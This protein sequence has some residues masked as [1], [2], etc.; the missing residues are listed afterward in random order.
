M[1]PFYWLVLSTIIIVAVACAYYP[2]LS[3]SFVWDDHDLVEKNTQVLSGKIIGGVFGSDFWVTFDDPSRFSE[4]YRP[5]IR[6]SFAID[7]RIYGLNAAGFHATNLLLHALAALLLAVVCMQLT[8]RFSAALVSALVFSLHPV[9]VESVAWISGRTDVLCLVFALASL[10]AV[11]EGLSRKGLRSFFALA[12]SVIFYAGALLSKETAAVLPFVLLAFI[13]LRSTGGR[14]KKGMLAAGLFF[15]ELSV[16][17]AIHIK[18]TGIDLGGD[19]GSIGERFTVSLAS[20]L[21]YLKLLILP[22][23]LKAHYGVEAVEPSFDTAA[24]AVILLF[25]ICAVIKWRETFKKVPGKNISHTD[26]EPLFAFAALL[27]AG[28]LLPVVVFPPYSDPILAERFLYFPGAA[29]ALIAGGA[30]AYF[31]GRRRLRW[32][33]LVAAAM[34]AAGYAAADNVRSRDWLD[35]YTLFAETARNTESPMIHGNYANALL[36]RHQIKQAISEFE[37]I[38]AGDPYEWR[39]LLNH[40][41]ALVSLGDY[42]A[43]GTK[44]EKALKINPESINAAVQLANV[45]DIQGRR[46]DASKM[47]DRALSISGSFAPAYYNLGVFYEKSKEYGPALTQYNKAIKLDP[48]YTNAYLGAANTCYLRGGYAE[49]EKY[50]LKIIELAGPDG[51]VFYDLAC[52]YSLHG[53]LESAFGALARAFENGYSA[54]E[55]AYKDPDLE[56]LRKSGERFALLVESSRSGSK[57]R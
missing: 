51:Q 15:I 43:A 38:E 13:F 31:V 55:W 1:K 47:Y 20:L 6:S 25:A 24:G 10:A 9:H 54:F 41:R 49:A 3:G 50:F 52:T 34:I 35:D 44:F 26:F 7:H 21:Y 39:A 11:F 5:L 30:G 28:T 56:A 42:E 45:L 14:L 57:A 23:P 48:Y 29:F 17:T 16:Y 32:P 37:I 53:E 27:L 18:I 19:F 8:G 4:F 33:A 2:G 36:E 12:A 22:Y 40:G 46:E